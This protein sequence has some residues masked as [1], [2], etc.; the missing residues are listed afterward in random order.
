M[1][2]IDDILMSFP[3]GQLMSFPFDDNFQLA[4]Y[5]GIKKF[6]KVLSSLSIWRFDYCCSR[7]RFFGSSNPHQFC[8]SKP[9]KKGRGVGDNTD[10]CN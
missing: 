5:I 10:R 8:Y 9:W 1:H 7:I 4:G 6:P 3:F 2:A